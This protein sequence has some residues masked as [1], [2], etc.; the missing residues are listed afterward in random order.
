MIASTN[1]HHVRSLRISFDNCGTSA[2]LKLDARTGEENSCDHFSITL[3]K[4]KEE[5]YLDLMRG[6]VNQL[7]SEISRIG[8]ARTLAKAS[9]E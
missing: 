2:W 6:L 3:F 9:R 7:E 4:R 8:T 1:I 5:S